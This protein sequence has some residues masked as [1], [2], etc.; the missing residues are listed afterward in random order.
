MTK[1]IFSIFNITLII[2]LCGCNKLVGGNLLEMVGMEFDLQIEMIEE[3]L[4]IN[5]EDLTD[6]SIETIYLETDPEGNS[7][8]IQSISLEG[9]GDCIEQKVKESNRWSLLPLNDAVDE[10]L[11]LNV[12]Y[13]QYDFENTTGY[14][15][16][17]GV[18]PN[19]E[20]FD[21]DQNNI[22]KWDVYEIGIWDSSDE[23]LYFNILPLF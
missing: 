15:T 10:V 21:F 14:F 13:D 19:G 16:V 1:T 2:A 4:S 7:V 5:L 20:G 3:C 18:F 11:A 23:T 8:S 9:A 12:V 6:D 17:S 22:D